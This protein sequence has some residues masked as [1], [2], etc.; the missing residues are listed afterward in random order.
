MQKS[1]QFLFHLGAVANFGY[2]I[3]Y[4]LF[5]LKLPEE[6]IKATSDYAGRWK[7]LTFWNM[8]II[9]LELPI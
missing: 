9:T 8:V 6:F 4:D 2:G 7:Y 5:K 3:Y 1:V